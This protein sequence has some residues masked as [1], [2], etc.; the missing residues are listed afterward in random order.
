MQFLNPY[1]YL[2]ILIVLGG[3]YGA[4]R[5]VVYDAV[6]HTTVQVEQK[7]KEAADSAQAQA[8][9]SSRLLQMSADKDKQTKDE[10]I[11]SITR[12]LSAAKRLLHSRPNRPPTIDYSSPKPSCTGRELYQEDG[13]FLVGEAARAEALI[14]ERDYY[15]QQYE[16]I[17]KELNGR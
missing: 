2:G 14:V 6:K 4:H 12:E 13:L 17:R 11:L 15:Y 10:K 5:W 1:Y 3:L 8:K 7:Y 16:N 9:E